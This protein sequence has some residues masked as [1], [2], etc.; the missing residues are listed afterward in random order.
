MSE[1]MPWYLQPPTEE[2]RRKYTVDQWNGFLEHLRPLFLESMIE[3][4]MRI[5]TMAMQGIAEPAKTKELPSWRDSKIKKFIEKVDAHSV[6]IKSV[7]KPDYDTIALFSEL[8]LT[9]SE[10]EF[11]DRKKNTMELTKDEIIF[12]VECVKMANLEGFYKLDANY[13]IDIEK[14]GRTCLQKIGIAESEIEYC[15]SANPFIGRPQE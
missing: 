6:E 15:F 7:K 8:E 1:E 4:R 2:E 5:A 11:R 13:D 14:V 12:L 3:Y 10:K 9:K